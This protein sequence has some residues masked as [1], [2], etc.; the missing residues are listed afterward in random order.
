MQDLNQ[1]K[2]M[3]AQKYFIFFTAYAMIGWLYETFLEVFIYQNGFSNRGFLFGPWCIV[4]GFGMVLLLFCLSKLKAKKIKIGPILITPLLIF[5]SVGFIATGVELI[6]SYLME[7]F[8]G[9]FMWN[10]K[11]FDFDFQGRI[12]P[13]PSIRFAVGGTFLLYVIQP[14]LNKLTKIMSKK[15]LNIST[16]I[17]LIIFITD[18]VYTVFFR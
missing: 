7:W 11:R 3:S 2:L 5:L 9:S 16:I 12:A 18:M 10:Y 13:N 15:S 8:T 6:A 4:Y 1:N 17:L 14:L